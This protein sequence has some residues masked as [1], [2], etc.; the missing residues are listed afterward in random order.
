M[1]TVYRG[2]EFFD[3]VENLPTF[4][5]SWHRPRPMSWAPHLS[6]MWSFWIT[7]LMWDMILHILEPP[8]PIPRRI[9]R[10]KTINTLT[11]FP[12]NWMVLTGC[13]MLLMSAITGQAPTFPILTVPAMLAHV[14]NCGMM[15][16]DRIARLD[17]MVVLNAE[18]FTQYQGLKLRMVCDVIE[19]RRYT[20]HIEDSEDDFNSGLITS[21]EENLYF[22]TY[23]ELPSET[24]EDQFFFDTVDIDPYQYFDPFG[25]HELCHVIDYIDCARTTA[26][27]ELMK[28]KSRGIIGPV[29]M[30]NK[31]GMSDEAFTLLA[32][33]A[34]AL[35]S[36]GGGQRQAVVFDTGASLGITFDKND[37]DCPL[38]IPEGDLRLGGMAQGLKI[39][40]VGPVTWT[41]RN[42]D[43]SELMIRSQCIMYLKPR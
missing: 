12:I 43:G 38:T 14:H 28:D 15:T 34:Y 11:V 16:Y 20:G 40:G 18:T 9:R 30:L 3:T 6:L 32:T 27:E 19:A 5:M 2:D 42:S 4:P 41:F 31:R 22:D 23:S 10:Q 33:D 17:D 7:T 39:E 24:G 37:F 8:R 1:V 26:S 21:E 35:I 29:M 36:I 13:L 25:I